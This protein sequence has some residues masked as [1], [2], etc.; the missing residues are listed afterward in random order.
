[1]AELRLAEVGMAFQ[2]GP[3]LAGLCATLGAGERV[4]LLGPSGVGKSTLLDLAAGLRAPSSGTLDNGFRR[5]AMIFQEPRLLPWRDALGNAGFGLAAQ[6]APARQVR[7]AAAA[8]LGDLG[9]PAQD[10]RKYPAQLSGGMAARVALARALLVAPD[11][12]LLDEPGAALDPGRRR[13]L[14][15]RVVQEARQRGAAFL[16][17]THDLMEALRVAER[18]W[19][20]D[21]RPGR[22]VEDLALPALPD[23][24]SRHACAAQLMRRPAFLNAFELG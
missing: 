20:L 12:L 13:Q 17:V 21:G 11:L 18:L 9:L 16:W 10:Q 8:L 15:D 24:A 1:M 23:A 22:L 6:G 19:L 7:A 2:G 5:T 4:A 3:V 14:Q